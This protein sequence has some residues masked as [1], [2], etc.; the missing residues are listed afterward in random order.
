MYE[1]DHS[2]FRDGE[3]EPK[4]DLRIAKRKRIQLIITS[5]LIYS[6]NYYIVLLFNIIIYDLIS[7][8]LCATA[9]FL[10][11]N[12]RNNIHNNVIKILK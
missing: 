8:F 5:S 1:Y 6:F 7:V 3:P 10:I 2:P 9:P 4:R 11:L 12:K